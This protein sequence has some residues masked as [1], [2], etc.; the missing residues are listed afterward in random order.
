MDNKMK[1]PVMPP[2]DQSE[3]PDSRRAMLSALLGGLGITALSGCLA[4]TDEGGGG[5]LGSTSLALH[6]GTSVAWVDTVFGYAYIATSAFSRAGGDLSTRTS[7]DLGATVAIASGSVN[8]ND[9]GGGIFFW[10]TGTDDGGTFI[11]PNGSI[12]SQGA[13]WQRV[14]SGPLNIAWFGAVRLNREMQVPIQN[15]INRAAQFSGPQPFTVPGAIYI[16]RGEYQ[17]GA[18][19]IIPNLG[20]GSGLSIRGDGPGRSSLIAT[21]GLGAATPVMVNDTTKVGIDSYFFQLEGLSMSRATKGPVFMYVGISTNGAQQDG[22]LRQAVFRDVTFISF[23]DAT[24]SDTQSPL[25]LSLCFDSLF[26]NVVVQGGE[27]ALRLAD[28]ARLTF[29]KL[30]VNLQGNNGRSGIY[31]GGGGTMSFRNIRIENPGTPDYQGIG[32]AITSSVVNGYPPANIVFD[33]LDFEN[34][35]GMSQQIYIAAGK[36]IMFINANLNPLSGIGV[37]IAAPV[38]NVR[39]IGG[40]FYVGGSSANAVMID[41]DASDIVFDQVRINGD[42][43]GNVNIDGRR[44]RA[45]LI[46]TG[47]DYGDPHYDDANKN[48]HAITMASGMIGTLLVYALPNSTAT[49]APSVR[50][51]D[52]WR[53]NAASEPGVDP[54]LITALIEGYD[55]QM[56]TLILETPTV[57]NG[58][59]QDGFR[60]RTWPS[61]TAGSPPA[62]VLNGVTGTIR[63]LYDHAN[64]VW[65]EVSRSFDA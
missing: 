16:P 57:L 41:P 14:F 31:I 29:N 17:I 42:V 28:C 58:T 1:Q 59:G 63:L 39:F 44:V 22:R 15:A 43:R 27:S 18:S 61:H 10:S 13:G 19:L 51:Y 56:L 53:V 30:S 3:G 45:D 60:L 20:Y 5:S 21:P 25:Y 35:G 34:H 24:Y 54:V 48:Y 65:H 49:G 36:E 32:I 46:W 11:V 55:G 23:Q 40:A 47:F 33:T 64:R 2:A 37:N 9:G 62:V 8:A 38:H 6:G 12:G 26:E 7:T 4:K 52:T 50:G